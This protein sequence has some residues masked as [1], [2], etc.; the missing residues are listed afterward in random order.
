MWAKDD[1][2]IINFP[3]P[4]RLSLDAA[5]THCFSIQ[6]LFRTLSRPKLESHRVLICLND[7]SL[8]IISLLYEDSL[9][10]HVLMLLRAAY[11]LHCAVGFIIG[12]N[13]LC[14]PC[15]DWI[16]TCTS[17]VSDQWSSTMLL[18]L[19]NNTYTRAFYLHK[20]E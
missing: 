19:P 8:M 11:H 14:S 15:S 20:V 17:Y 7:Y 3:R 1:R 13:W 5:I 4:R 6:V 10:L 2:M 16:S 18:H 9:G 12:Q